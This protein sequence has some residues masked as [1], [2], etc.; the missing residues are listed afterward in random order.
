[1]IAI[2]GRTRAAFEP[3]DVVRT[4]RRYLDDHTRTHPAAL[5]RRLCAR[6][7]VWAARRCDGGTAGRA[8]RR[9]AGTGRAVGGARRR[10]AEYDVSWRQC[11]EDRIARGCGGDAASAAGAEA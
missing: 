11:D 2:A 3:S 1:M 5:A 8:A 10:G 9:R 7:P 4:H 6:W